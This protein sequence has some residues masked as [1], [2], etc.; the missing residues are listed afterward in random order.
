MKLKSL[1][2]DRLA[3][4]VYSEDEAP[5]RMAKLEEEKEQREAALRASGSLD[6]SLVK[7][8]APPKLDQKVRPAQL[9]L[10]KAY[11]NVERFVV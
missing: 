11:V 9:I 4:K 1:P 3:L 6:F 10:T 8:I 5:R 7:R 2:R